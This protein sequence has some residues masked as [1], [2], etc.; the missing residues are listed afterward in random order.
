MLI[1]S[2]YKIMIFCLVSTILIE[3]ISAYILKIRDKKDY[4][5]I[6][7]VNV[8]TNPIVVLFPYVIYLYL[9]VIYRFILIIILEILAVLVEGLFYK[10]YLK[11]NEINYFKLSLILNLVSYGV[12]VIID[13]FV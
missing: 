9:G 6:F 10:K 3:F 11:F 7:L 4:L 12:G 2:F 1:N 5:N 8:I 13:I